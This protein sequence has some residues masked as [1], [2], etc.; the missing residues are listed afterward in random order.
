MGRLLAQC[1][2]IVWDEVSMANKKALEA[3]QNTS[4]DI[5]DAKDACKGGM[6]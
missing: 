4:Q 5:R 6:F 1:S 2:M 3:L